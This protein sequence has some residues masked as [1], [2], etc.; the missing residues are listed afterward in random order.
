M[1]DPKN[2]IVYGIGQSLREHAEQKRIR[3]AGKEQKADRRD[4]LRRQ[5]KQDRINARERRSAP[6]QKS[7]RRAL[8][9]AGVLTV[10]LWLSPVMLGDF[11][12][13][14][15]RLRDLWVPLVL[16]AWVFAALAGLW[17][18]FVG[19]RE[20]G[21]SVM[22]NWMGA[23]WAASAL[24]SL[25]VLFVKIVPPGPSAAYLVR[26][27]YITGFAVVA[28]YFWIA[29]GFAAA[30]ARRAIERQLRQRNAVLHPARLRPARRWFFLWLW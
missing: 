22:P 30:S 26:G 6:A 16:W 11:L 17:G 8:W 23:F 2:S 3:Q 20:A 13:A 25:G 7:L 12:P 19:L 1:Y 24:V 27:L 5:R 18:L 10:C 14:L 29:A 4:A 21:K 28:V 9:G 15:W